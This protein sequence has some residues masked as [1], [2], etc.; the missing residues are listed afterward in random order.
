MIACR[1]FLQQR[2]IESLKNESLSIISPRLP[3]DSTVIPRLSIQPILACPCFPRARGVHCTIDLLLRTVSRVDV[4]QART[5]ERG[6]I[7]VVDPDEVRLV[8]EEPGELQDASAA[9]DSVWVGRR[10]GLPNE[11][12]SEYKEKDGGG[13]A[14]DHGY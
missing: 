2:G 14:H 5:A 6:D 7:R 10:E 13:K 3:R 1:L 11:N 9:N 12:D 4:E 8:P